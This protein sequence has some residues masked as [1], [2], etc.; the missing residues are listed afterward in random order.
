MCFSVIRTATLEDIEKSYY[1]VI[2]IAKLN[3]TNAPMLLSGH[4]QETIFTIEWKGWIY[5]IWKGTRLIDILLGRRSSCTV[6]I[7]SHEGSKTNYRS[8]SSMGESNSV[9]NWRT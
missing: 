5:I 2:E 7:L 3:N 1:R 9:D 4:I 8:I 6:H